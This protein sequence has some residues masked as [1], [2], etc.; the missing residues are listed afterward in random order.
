MLDRNNNDFFLQLQTYAFYKTLIVI[1]LLLIIG[2]VFVIPYDSYDY[3]RYFILFVMLIYGM[4]LLVTILT[5]IVLEKHHVKQM[6]YFIISMSL[7]IFSN[8]FYTTALGSGTSFIFFGLLM[9]I[10]L[11]QKAK[12][13]VMAI[14]ISITYYAVTMIVYWN[15]RVIFIGVGYYIN[16]FIALFAMLYILMVG[17][18]LF[19]YYQEIIISQMQEL[20]YKNSSLKLLNKELK[21]TK[22]SLEAQ[23]DKIYHLAY[24]DPLTK[25]SNRTFFLDNLSTQYNSEGLST[26]TIMILDIDNLKY[27]ND[28]YSYSVGDMVIHEVSHKL[29]DL[30]GE[31]ATISRIGGDEIAML[32]IGKVDYEFTAEKIVMLFSQPLSIPD[33]EL[34]VSVNIGIVSCDKKDVLYDEALRYADIALVKAKNE[35]KGSSHYVVYDPKMSKKIYEQIHISKELQNAIANGDIEVDYQHKNNTITKKI[36]GFEALARWNH[37][38]FG[39][40]SPLKFI[41]IAEQFGLISRLT[42]YILEKVC[43]FARAVNEVE[44]QYIITIN[45]SG[46]DL[47]QENFYQRIVGLLYQTNTRASIVGIEVTETAIMESLEMATPNLKRLREHG[48]RISMD[49]FGTGYSSLNYLRK[50]PIDVLKID[51]SFIDGICTSAYDHYMV[52]MIVDLA[53]ELGIETMAEGV[54]QKEQYEVLKALKCTGIQGYYFSKPISFDEALA[55][56]KQ[57]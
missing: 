34:Q 44:D 38:E 55:K 47:I 4:L 32:F 20:N 8:V 1:E 31:E 29:G 49:D 21:D 24:Y 54:E 42:E 23:Y 14:I 28:I 45:I 50:L 48:L 43:E 26:Y 13:V 36:N 3:P 15:Q 41:V 39:F 52:R 17:L 57:V 46:V 35:Y 18:K 11:M 10:Y 6:V 9:T 12:Y 19:R 16:R 7:Y 37:K 25:L 33:I 27:I 53:N 51:K 2:S 30:L 56:T 40:V 5:H 22:K